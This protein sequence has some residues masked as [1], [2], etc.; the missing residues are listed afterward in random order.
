[1]KGWL[2]AVAG[3]FFAIV[4]FMNIGCAQVEP[5]SPVERARAPRNFDE[6]VQDQGRVLKS[7]PPQCVTADGKVFVQESGK[8]GKACKDLCGD[9]RCEE[10]VCM[11]V[12]CPCAESRQ[13][14]PQDCSE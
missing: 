3:M 1:M 4:T 14:C 6:C 5:S 12:G 9:G 11:A 7:L 13:S 10:I 2:L 8:P